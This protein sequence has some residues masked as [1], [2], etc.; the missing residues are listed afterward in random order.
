MSAKLRSQPIPVVPHTR[1]EEES[2]LDKIYHRVKTLG[3]G[4]FGVV[5]KAVHR[6]SGRHWAIKIIHKEKAGSSAIRNLEREVNIMKMVQHE[7]I[8]KLHEV[9]E[10]S[11][12]MYLVM[13]LCDGGEILIDLKN[14]GS[15][16]ENQTRTIMKRLAS[17]VAYLDDHNI[18]H[19]D[20]KL[21]NILLKKSGDERSLNIKVSDFGLACIVLDQSGYAM[22]QTT[23]GTP[24]YMAPEVINDL[25]YTRKCDVWSIGVIMYMLL[26]GEGPFIADD[27]DKLFEL[28]K[29]GEITFNQPI[30]KTVSDSAKELLQRILCVN[31]A[32][33]Y[34]AK[35]IL[36][37]SWITV[38]V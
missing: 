37:H 31:T 33:R 18:V 26:C 10:T 14:R 36:N 13:E 25:G 30:W 20:L 2:D 15:Y 34:T 22:M 16:T 27:E 5:Y 21:A 4:G 19:R 29:K 24:L 23:C 7:H 38:C 32:K 11:K 9:Y 17:A 6:Q 1:I 12:Q 8:V 28:I 3:K 35:E